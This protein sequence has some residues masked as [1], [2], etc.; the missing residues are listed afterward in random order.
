MILY[1]DIDGVVS[2]MT[3]ENAFGD[4]R[5]LRLDG[6]HLNLSRQLGTRLS[7]LDASVRWLSTWGVRAREVGDLLGV[8]RWP[9]AIEPPAGATSSG[10]WKFDCVRSQIEAEGQAF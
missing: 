1:L 2:S 3:S 10:P 5:V 6:F 7:A 4:G 9:V 8:P